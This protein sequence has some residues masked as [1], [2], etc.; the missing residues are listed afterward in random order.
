[1]A[2]GSRIPTWP[3]VSPKFTRQSHLRLCA[4]GNLVFSSLRSIG[5]VGC[6]RAAN[7]VYDAVDAF[8]LRNLHD[9]L[10]DA[11]GINIQS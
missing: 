5:R 7:A 9:P 1:M 8:V 3:R 10:A 4:T 11:G 6:D 2:A